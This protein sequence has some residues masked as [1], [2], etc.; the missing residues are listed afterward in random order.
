LNSLAAAAFLILLWEPR[1][2]F[3]AGFQL[4]FFVMLTIG[5]LLQ[6]LNRFTDGR[7]RPDPVLPEELLPKWRRL[8]WSSL[9]AGARYF[10]LSLA[11]WIGSIPLSAKY[12][13]LF[14]PVSPLANL[15]AVPLGTLAL[16]AD[17]GALMCGTWFTWGTE[18]FNNAAW[19][20]M[21][22]MTDVS[23]WATR[24][25]GAYF[26]VPEPS[27]ISIVLFYA[28][29]VL[30]WSGW[31]SS[32]GRKVIAATA[33][34]IV[35]AAWFCHWELTRPEL[36]MTVL[37]LNGGHAVY[38]AGRDGE[39]LIDSGNAAAVESTVKPFLRG[40]G[41]NHIP[42]LALTGGNIRNYG[43]AGMLDELFGV[44]ELWTSPAHFRSSGY[45]EIVSKFEAPDTRHR[46]VSA[47]ERVRGWQVLWP[48]ATNHFARADDDA[49]VLR[50]SCRGTRILL[51][52][53]LGRAGQSALLSLTNDLSADIV[54]AGL[55]DD[56]EPLSEAMLAAIH[57]KVIVIAD[58]EYP[59]SRRSKPGLKE[60]LEQK[61]IPV[62]YTRTAGA[63]KVDVDKNGWC[64]TTMD[65]RR[66]SSVS[67]SR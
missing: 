16:M 55:P 37:P 50:T 1:Q 38:V 33:S 10:S 59:A 18:R 48:G 45:N 3:E 32:P 2:L 62:I 31:L 63:V 67:S 43:G 52:G 20:F 21:N 11:A 23:E 39:W 12:F 17:L 65:G 53:D 41:V 14:S 40:Q 27:W 22:A 54:V 42:R 61:A 8:L 44:D 28:V 66:F 47:G 30:W 25:P 26:Y 35:V 64:L 57:P 19:F 58:S 56:E 15:V 49:L 60:R 6:P 34:V 7:L 29:L 9:R 36:T 24:I 13:H 46:T 5:L 4:S 51:L